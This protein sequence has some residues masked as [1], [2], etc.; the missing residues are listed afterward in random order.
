MGFKADLFGLDDLGGNVAEWCQDW[1]DDTQT[2]R[3][4]RFSRSNGRAA[5]PTRHE[6]HE[7]VAISTSSRCFR[8]NSTKRPEA[9]RSDS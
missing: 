5:L 1:F 2:E 9:A 7:N 4:L 8:A 3:V 6:R